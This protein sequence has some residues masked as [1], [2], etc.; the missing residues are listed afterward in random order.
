MKSKKPDLTKAGTPRLRKPG[1]GRKPAT[2]P[3]A[4]R[5]RITAHVTP[6][7]WDL[8]DAVQLEQGCSIGDALSILLIS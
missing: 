8:I 4:N 7:V 2:I 6:A 5:I 3:T 1:A